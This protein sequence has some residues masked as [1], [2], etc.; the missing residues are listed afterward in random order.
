MEK[1][2]ESLG[3]AKLSQSDIWNEALPGSEALDNTAQQS[4]LGFDGAEVVGD[5]IW[6]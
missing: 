1:A 3:R 2:Q 6:R 4:L 5:V